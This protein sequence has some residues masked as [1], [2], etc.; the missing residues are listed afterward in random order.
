[1]HIGRVVHPCTAPRFSIEKYAALNTA[2]EASMKEDIGIV[3]FGIWY[4]VLDQLLVD[5][6]KPNLDFS[7]MKLAD[8]HQAF[9]EW[10]AANPAVTEL[11]YLYIC[12]S[13]SVQDIF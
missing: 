10:I 3:W 6:P 2:V 8:V 13:S 9:S 5:L 4:S 12:Y 7:D 1:M 11:K